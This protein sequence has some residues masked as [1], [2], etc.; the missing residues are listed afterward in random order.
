MSDAFIEK[1][2]NS[3]SQSV[4]E[5]A[6][7]LTALPRHA[8]DKQDAGQCHFHPFRVCSCGKCKDREQFE[9]EGKDYHTKHVS[10]CPLHSLAY[11]IECK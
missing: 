1:A 3:E 6:V 5:F 2:R 8:H 11:K 9:C 4:E 7:R 10:S